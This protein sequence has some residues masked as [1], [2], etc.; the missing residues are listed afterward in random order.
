MAAVKPEDKIAMMKAGYWAGFVAMRDRKVKEGVGRAKAN[1]ESLAAVMPLVR[2]KLAELEADGV[3]VDEMEVRRPGAVQ[4]PGMQARELEALEQELEEVAVVD[5]VAVSAPGDVVEVVRAKRTATSEQP[6]A[7]GLV[8]EP[9][10]E[11]AGFE[12]SA[13]LEAVLGG[14]D[15][16]SPSEPSELKAAEFDR[17]MKWVVGVLERKG[18]V[19]A[20][21][22][23]SGMAWAYYRMCKDSVAFREKFL[24]KM[25][26]RMLPRDMSGAGSGAED[27]GLGVERG[28]VDYMAEV[29]EMARAAEGVD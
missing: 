28:L 8:V 24:M 21:D 18:P 19:R 2:K 3:D 13:D 27:D 15:V 16:G 25:L 26:E 6:D 11:P 23:P 17:Q 1:R 10:T 14:I 7:V 5:G 22:A 4:I 9:G 12:R 20:D 29:A